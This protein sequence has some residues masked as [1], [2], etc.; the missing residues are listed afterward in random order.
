M[1]SPFTPNILELPNALPIFP[2]NGAV[3]LPH[4][5]LPLNIFENRYLNMVS[6][7]LAG[8]RLI[9]MIQPIDG[10]KDEPLDV[11]RTGCV[12]RIA[13]FTETRDGRIQIVLSGICRFDIERELQDIND[14]RYAE[15][16]WDRFA[17][18][19]D[20]SEIDYCRD[21]L[22]SIVK[23]YLNLQG[24]TIEWKL[25]D[26]LEFPELIDTLCSILPF[27]PREKQGLVE[28]LTIQDRCE[29]LAALCEFAVQPASGGE[30]LTH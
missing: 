12:G 6:D 11:Y 10:E 1:R 19:F 5:Q 16:S 30:D 23:K 17:H 9:G 18:D 2:L 20:D 7:T 13:S 21:R 22:L 3:V 28:S 27:L 14:Y 4:G 25:L 15:V 26:N 24:L 8:N 29:L